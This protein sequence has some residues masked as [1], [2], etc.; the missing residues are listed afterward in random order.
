MRDLWQRCGHA[1]CQPAFV[2]PHFAATAAVGHAPLPEAEE[3]GRVKKSA[4][5]ALPGATMETNPR[6]LPALGGCFWPAS[7]M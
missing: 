7:R 1:L 2:L 6:P 4:P 5:P 3:L